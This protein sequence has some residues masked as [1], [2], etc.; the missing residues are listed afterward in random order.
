MMKKLL[1]MMLCILFV[2]GTALGETEF[3]EL[4]FDDLL[5]LKKSVDLEY[6]SR[7]ESEGI[8]LY[9][10]TYVVGTDIKPG[11]YFAASVEPNDINTGAYLSIYEDMETFNREE[12]FYHKL[13]KYYEF[14]GLGDQPE[15]IILDA[16]NVIFLEYGS[17]L[18]KSEP[19]DPEKY[20]TYI[21]PEGTIVPPGTYTVGDDIPVGK[22]NAYPATLS[23]G[24]FKVLIRVIGDD[25]SSSL[26]TKN[27][28][29]S[30]T[31]I[32]VR[33]NQKYE[34]LDLEEGDILEVRNSI[35][36]KK[37]PKLVFDD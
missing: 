31:F 28:M 22:Y 6:A 29:Y 36:M 16:G 17:V 34:P 32:G 13:A 1:I 11:H 12:E 21:P 3:S 2:S 27:G 14:C 23:G 24:E 37:Q 20:Y 26:V 15:S 8:M 4:P 5:T 9:S 10:G 18:L 19:F 30:Y 7:P 25:G 35:V 33:K